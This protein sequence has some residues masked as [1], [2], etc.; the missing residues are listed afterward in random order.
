MKNL[1]ALFGLTCMSLSCMAQLCQITNGSFESWVYQDTATGLNGDT[2]IYNHPTGWEPFFGIL[3]DSTNI[4]EIPGYQSN[5]AMRL[6]NTS[7]GEGVLISSFAFCLNKSISKFSVRYKFDGYL[8]DSASAIVLIMD[9]FL[10]DVYGAGIIEFDHQ[11]QWTYSETPV[12]YDSIPDDT[13]FVMILMATGSGDIN[14]TTPNLNLDIDE[15]SAEWKSF[16]QL[17]LNEP[18]TKDLVIYPNPA[19]TFLGLKHVPSQGH[20]EVYNL[21]GQKVFEE[22]VEKGD[23]EIQIE[24]LPNGIYLLRLGGPDWEY[25]RK[26]I[27]SGD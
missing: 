17:S 21:Q 3:Y 9:D 5:S 27:K 10:G 26:I 4:Q 6:H 8:S 18:E 13:V 24:A 22:Q 15:F 25:T 23:Q 2:T 1:T 7:Q 11:T 19:S 14:Q 12:F 16:N 20:L